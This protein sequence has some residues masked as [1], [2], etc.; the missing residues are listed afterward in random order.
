MSR[1]ARRL[2]ALLVSVLFWGLL[3][4]STDCR[5][6]EQSV[7][8]AKSTAVTIWVSLDSAGNPVA[9]PDK[10][11]VL[12][13]SKHEYADWQLAPGQD[14]KFSIQFKGETPGTE[15]GVPA[16]TDGPKPK[17]KRCRSIV[18]RDKHYGKHTYEITK[19]SPQGTTKSDPEIE[20]DR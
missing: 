5:R 7:S 1:S 17:D 4:G 16:C 9:Y 14:F 20:V 3:L 10:G 11:V 6:V 19:I 2:P 8:T 12:S 18:P 13:V 15:L